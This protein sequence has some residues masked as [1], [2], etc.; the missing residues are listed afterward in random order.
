[1][2]ALDS[3]LPE[4]ERAVDERVECVALSKLNREELH[5]VIYK[6]VERSRIG[7]LDPSRYFE[8]LVERATERHADMIEAHEHSV[9]IR[10]KVLRHLLDVVRPALPA[11]MSPIVIRTQRDEDQAFDEEQFHPHLLGCELL[12][13]EKKGSRRRSGS[14]QPITGRSWWLVALPTEDRLDPMVARYAVAN[15]SGCRTSMGITR[16]L[17][18]RL[19][20]V[21]EAAAQIHDEQFVKLIKSLHERLIAITGPK[22]SRLTDG[23][24]SVADSLDM[25]LTAMQS[26]GDSFEQEVID[27]G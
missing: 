2:I 22:G 15:H 26:A 18:L 20:T 17:D 3:V 12:N 16:S 21:E 6:L 23:L 27:L 19:T 4:L 14:F 25:A 9:A 10:A 13:A 11:L 8:Q 24:W 5:D 7:S 1:V